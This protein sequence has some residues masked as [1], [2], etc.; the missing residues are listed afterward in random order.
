MSS[1][2][3]FY[4]FPVFK[5]AEAAL[6]LPQQIL[7]RRVR[8][9]L[10]RLAVY[11]EG[12]YLLRR[13]GDN[14]SHCGKRAFAQRDDLPH[15]RR[16]AAT[17]AYYAARQAQQRTFRLRPAAFRAAAKLRRIARKAH[18]PQLERGLDKRRGVHFSAERVQ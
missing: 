3:L 6:R 11:G 4:L 16:L 18:Q 1:V 5:R 7:L 14:I 2:Y 9:S 13:S 10:Q 12:E 17:A 8:E 15:R